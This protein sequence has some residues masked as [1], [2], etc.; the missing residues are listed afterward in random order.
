M[1]LTL[2]STSILWT[3]TS[4]EDFHACLIQNLTRHQNSLFVGQLS[5]VAVLES[6]RKAAD[7]DKDLNT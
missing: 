7:E 1:G 4:Q 2:F 5:I 3:A 6:M